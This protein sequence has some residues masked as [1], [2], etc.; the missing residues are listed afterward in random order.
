ML[1]VDFRFVE[2]FVFLKWRQ[3]DGDAIVIRIAQLVPAESGEHHGDVIFTAAVIRAGNQGRTSSR[4]VI[5]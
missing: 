2:R 1:G 4:Q 3:L 5:P